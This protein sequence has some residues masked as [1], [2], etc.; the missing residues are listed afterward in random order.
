ML[1]AFKRK[2]GRLLPKKKAPPPKPA[3][4]SAPVVVKELHD[5]TF[6]P[7]LW[8]PSPDSEGA[9]DTADMDKIQNVLSAGAQKWNSGTF[10]FVKTLQSAQRNHGRVDMFKLEG[11]VTGGYLAAAAGYAVEAVGTGRCVAVKRMPTRWVRTGPREFTSQYPRASERPWFD[12]ACTTLLNQRGFPYVN[13]LHGI[14]RDEENTFVVMSLASDGDLFK[15]C[16]NKIMPGPKREILMRPIL[17]QVFAGVCFMHNIGIAHRDL[18]LEN[19]LLSRGANGVSRVKI[20]DFGMAT[21][22]RKVR[23]EVCGKQSYQAP[24]VHL[25]KAYDTFLADAFSLGVMCFAMAVQDYPWISTKRNSCQLFEYVRT[26]G[27]SQFMSKRQLRKGNGEYLKDV[28]SPD[29]FEMV[30]GFLTMAPEERLTLGEEDLMKQDSNT[31][32]RSVWDMR[33]IDEHGGDHEL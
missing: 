33:W 8:A 6:E 18:S 4:P 11:S 31:S 14:Y 29:L 5:H 16:D 12:F 9:V 23:R 28:M 26:Y 13:F 17:R 1:D 3:I 21:L 7:G 30:D 20:I 27:L 22:D 2:F 25:D 32:C 15:W 10:G 19:V 24:E